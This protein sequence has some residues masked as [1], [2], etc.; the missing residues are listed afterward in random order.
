MTILITLGFALPASRAE[1]AQEIL[2]GTTREELLAVGGI[3]PVIDWPRAVSTRRWGDFACMIA[4]TTSPLYVP[5]RHQNK[6]GSGYRY[7]VPADVRRANGGGSGMT[8][9]FNTNY[10]YMRRSSLAQSKLT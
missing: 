4:L 6:D 8:K 1:K 7:P 9:W 3:A 2:A 10:H 5:P